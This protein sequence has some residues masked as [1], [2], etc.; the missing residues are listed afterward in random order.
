MM[1]CRHLLW[2]PSRWYPHLSEKGA[3]APRP[4]HSAQVLPGQDPGWQAS[5]AACLGPE[6]PQMSP[7]WQLLSVRLGHIQAR[8]KFMASKNACLRSPLSYTPAV[9]SESTLRTLT[10]IKFQ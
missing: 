7:Q 8:G 2:R 4:E 1:T 3:R 6:A 10:H 5:P 9:N